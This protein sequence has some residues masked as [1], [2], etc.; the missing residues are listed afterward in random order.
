MKKH[1]V[2]FEDSSKQTFGGGQ[3]GTLQTIHSLKNI[4]TLH[5]FDT[6]T[7]SVFFTRAS[8][9]IPDGFRH[10][11]KG[12]GR[13]AQGGRQASFSIGWREIL[14]FPFTHIYN[15]LAVTRYLNANKLNKHNTIFYVATKKGLLLT[16]FLSL[17]TGVKIVFHARTYD[18]KTNLFYTLMSISYSRC[19]TIICVSQFIYRHISCAQAVVVYNPLT[20]PPGQPEPKD[21]RGTMVVATISSLIHWKGIEYFLKSFACLPPH[22]NIEYHIYGNGELFETLRNTYASDRIKFMGF[23]DHIDEILQKTI[24]VICVPSI[25]PEAFGR[26][27][28]EGFK[29]GI[30]A[31]SSNIGA[32]PEVVR[33]GHTGFLV[34]PRAPTAIADKIYQLYRDPDLYRLMSRQAIAESR[35][36]SMEH[37]TNAIKNIFTNIH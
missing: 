31:I 30:P 8:E 6:N 37:Y 1:I 23:C 21:L 33:E 18:N 24:H 34:P 35:R 32:Q 22:I 12:H 4:F 28:V 10:T 11:I 20:L 16:F 14:F 2:V 27:S 25:Q 5:L 17:I 29:Y 7:Q 3:K 13:I 36:F 15:I 26:T 19:E 9:L